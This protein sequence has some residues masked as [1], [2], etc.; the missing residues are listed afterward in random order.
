M[1]YL[2]TALKLICSKNTLPDNRFT[3]QNKKQLSFTSI[4]V[5]NIKIKTLDPYGKFVPTSAVFSKLKTNTEE[6]LEA[7]FNILENWKNTDYGE[8]FSNSFIHNKPRR[9]TGYYAIELKDS[10][11]PLYEKILCVIKTEVLKYHTTGKRNLQLCFLQGSPD[12]I[13]APFRT[14][15]GLG[16]LS[17]YGVVKLAKAKK[18]DGIEVI[19]T[20]DSFY[21]HIA[22]FQTLEKLDK[23][24]SALYLDKSKFE[25][26]L[27]R[28]KAKYSF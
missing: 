13:D 20:N 23:E 2:N 10:L 14:I 26:F 19:S 12:V 21:N 27:S 22:D 1:V 17:L 7:V 8:S 16:D 6:D 25:P 5:Y 3:L 11:K 9:D 4:P 24:G 18:V 28:I 15:K